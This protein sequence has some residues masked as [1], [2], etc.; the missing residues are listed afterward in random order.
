MEKIMEA[1]NKNIKLQ[2]D[3]NQAELRARMQSSIQSL[4]R[5][6]AQLERPEFAE[7][8]RFAVLWERLGHELNALRSTI[9]ERHGAETSQPD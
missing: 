3:P 5:A 1:L 7:Y 4:E 2:E 8:I 9:R 6:F